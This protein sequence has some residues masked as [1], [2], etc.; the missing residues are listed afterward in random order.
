MVRKSFQSLRVRSGILIDEMKNILACLFVK[1]QELF[2]ALNS[3]SGTISIDPPFSIGWWGSRVAI[4]REKE[5][6]TRQ[7]E[8]GSGS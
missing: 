2:K 3:K 1:S 5:D 7:S 8:P 6:R 4:I